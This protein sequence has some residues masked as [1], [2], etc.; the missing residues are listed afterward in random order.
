MLYYIYNRH[1]IVLIMI[2]IYMLYLRPVKEERKEKRHFS[3]MLSYVM[4]L[5]T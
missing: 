3:A 4:H 1:S 2:Y 5:L